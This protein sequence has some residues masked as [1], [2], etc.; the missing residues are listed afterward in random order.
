[1]NEQLCSLIAAVPR[2]N[3]IRMQSEFLWSNLVADVAQVSI[4]EQTFHFAH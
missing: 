2:Q 1:V 4:P 3:L